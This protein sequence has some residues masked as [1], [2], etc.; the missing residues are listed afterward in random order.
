VRSISASLA[1][2]GGRPDVD[3]TIAA[4]S[5]N[6][7]RYPLHVSLAVVPDFAK[8][9][10]RKEAVVIP[11]AAHAGALSVIASRAMAAALILL[12]HDAPLA[13]GH[14]PG[15]SSRLEHSEG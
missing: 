2:Q 10:V 13:G 7:T 8:Q 4:P 11:S 6:P 9:S 12:M 5:T 14:S 15:P 1:H 3:A